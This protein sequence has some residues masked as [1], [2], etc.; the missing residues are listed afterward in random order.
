MS[1]CNRLD[2]QTL[3]SQPVM[4]KN[5]PDHWSSQRISFFRSL[6]NQSARAHTHL[7]KTHTRAR[8][9]THL[10]KTH[11]HTRAHTHTQG[12]YEVFVTLIDLSRHMLWPSA[13][14][15]LFWELDDILFLDTLHREVLRRVLNKNVQC[16]KLGLSIQRRCICMAKW[17]VRPQTVQSK[18][19]FNL[20]GST[21]TT[22]QPTNLACSFLRS[23]QNWY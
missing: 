17:N 11:T 19:V 15:A 4:P 23:L 7:L 9:H 1:T 18:E 20:T 14:G 2:L 12:K 13:E 10:L 22:L 16:S 3:G 5:L 21:V 8:T 6:F